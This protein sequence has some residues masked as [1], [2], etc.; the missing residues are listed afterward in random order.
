MTGLPG[1]DEG[2]ARFRDLTTQQ[3]ARLRDELI[4]S[5]LGLAHQ[6]ARRFAGRG[7]PHDDLVQVASLALVKAI[8][9]F[10]PERGVQFSTFA[11]KCVIGELKRH[12]RDRGWAVRAPRRIQ[13]LYLEV[14]QNIDRLSQEL[15][16]P[17]TVAE[18]AAAIGTTE[19]AVLEA[20][21]AGR[22]YRSASLD[23]PDLNSQ[24]MADSLGSDDARYSH[25][26]DRSVLAGALEALPERD[27]VI[28]RLRFID[29]LTQ[30]E[31]ADRLGVSQMHI[32]RLLAASLAQLRASFADDRR[33][34]EA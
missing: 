21:E 3:D 24:T 23:A 32:S 18:L 10:D 14:G 17:P 19:D 27:R 20:I 33:S 29:G 22:G 12:F 34:L 1:G 9:R 4:T 16:H 31:I 11:A 26:E 5:H 28:I 25:V 30:S 15:G 7:E 6:L 2:L 13:E 8:D